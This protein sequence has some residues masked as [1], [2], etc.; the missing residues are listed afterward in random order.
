VW[1][2]TKVSHCKPGESQLIPKYYRGRI[3]FQDG[4]GRYDEAPTDSEIMFGCDENRRFT[5][6]IEKSPDGDTG[7]RDSLTPHC[8]IGNLKSGTMIHLL[9]NVE[10]KFRRS[11]HNIST[12][13]ATSDQPRQNSHQPPSSSR[14]NNPT[15]EAGELTR[16]YCQGKDYGDTRATQAAT[17]SWSGTD[18]GSNP[19]EKSRA[20]V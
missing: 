1:D 12:F 17:G 10:N 16:G 15:S 18:N 7:T 2:R 6:V 4:D 5:S 9:Q 8:S 19:D 13:H 14:P 20:R 3:V 11:F